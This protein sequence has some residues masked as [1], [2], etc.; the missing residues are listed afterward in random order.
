MTHNHSQ[1]FWRNKEIII[2]NRESIF[3]SSLPRQDSR[4]LL[5]QQNVLS[6]RPLMNSAC[7]SGGGAAGFSAAEA[8]LQRSCSGLYGHKS[9]LLP[10]SKLA[11]PSISG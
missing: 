11:Q 7:L 6:G 1:L 8:A 9:P 3:T 5:P 2:K 10:Y 4:T